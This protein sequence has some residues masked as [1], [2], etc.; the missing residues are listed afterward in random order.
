MRRCARW[1]VR[2]QRQ[3]DDPNV[4]FVIAVLDVILFLNFHWAQK[5]VQFGLRLYEV[6]QRASFCTASIVEEQ[7]SFY[8]TL[9]QAHVLI[10]ILARRNRDWHLRW[11]DCLFSFSKN[12][13]E[14]LSRRESMRPNAQNQSFIKWAPRRKQM[15]HN[16]DCFERFVDFGELNGL[17]LT[18][19]QL[20]QLIPTDSLL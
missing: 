15:W 12:K 17:L 8:S 9:F 5:C 16:L 4:I 7:V 11:R 20:T 14:S 1:M 18:V 3:L 10:A 13:R 19:L 2:C 6:Y